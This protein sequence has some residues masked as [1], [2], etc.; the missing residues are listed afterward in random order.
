MNIDFDSYFDY[1]WIGDSRHAEYYDCVGYEKRLSDCDSANHTSLQGLIAP[2]VS[3]V[4]FSGQSKAFKRHRLSYYI[5]LI[6]Q[7]PA[8][9]VILGWRREL[10]HGRGGW[11]CASVEGGAL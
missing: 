5:A 3:L 8:L 2:A 4:C 6:T 11:R 10:Y 9:M 1:K 7:K